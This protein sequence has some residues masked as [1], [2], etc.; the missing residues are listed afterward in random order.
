[1]TCLVF[2]KLISNATGFVSNINRL[3]DMTEIDFNM[4]KFEL[5]LNIF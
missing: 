3:K 5:I 4:I 1:M 2:T